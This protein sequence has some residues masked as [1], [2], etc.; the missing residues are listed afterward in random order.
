PAAIPIGL[1]ALIDIGPPSASVESLFAR[2]VGTGIGRRRRLQDAAEDVVRYETDIAGCVR[3]G[4][5]RDR[6]RTECESREREQNSLLHG[7]F[8]HCAKA[9]L[10]R[11]AQCTNRA[12]KKKLFDS[13]AYADVWRKRDRVRES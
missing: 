10:E 8:L 2:P 7:A 5:R 12:T 13:M 3:E 1:G 4:R 9:L 6:R 11:H